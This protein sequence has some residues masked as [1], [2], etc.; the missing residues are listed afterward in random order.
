MRSYQ[1]YHRLVTGEGRKRDVSTLRD[2]GRRISEM[3]AQSPKCREVR[4]RDF[5]KTKSTRVG[6][7]KTPSKQPMPH[8][9]NAGLESSAYELVDIWFKVKS[10]PSVFNEVSVAITKYDPIANESM[11]MGHLGGVLAESCRQLKIG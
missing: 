4:V 7:C 3:S 10:H 9:Q 2:V 11:A 5:N 8:Y 6:P 1:S